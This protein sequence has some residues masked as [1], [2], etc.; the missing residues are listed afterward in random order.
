MD[1]GFPMT[2]DNAPLQCLFLDSFNNKKQNTLHHWIEHV[3]ISRT[4]LFSALE[5]VFV[6]LKC[7]KS[8]LKCQNHK[9]DAFSLFQSHTSV[10]H[11]EET[12]STSFTA[13]LKWL[14]KQQLSPKS[15][16]LPSKSKK[17]KTTPRQTHKHPKI[18]S[19]QH[20]QNSN[21]R[22]KSREKHTQGSER[23]EKDR[24]ATIVNQP[25]YLI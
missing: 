5:M 8:S 12:S 13:G 11:D 20:I 19:D 24:T 18:W 22:F 6:V 2:M 4:V 14:I 3:N 10:F 23:C 15:T 9:K 21:F 16:I 1:N 7:A 25:Y 17:Q